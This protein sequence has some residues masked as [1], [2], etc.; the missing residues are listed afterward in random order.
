MLLF[1]H[2]FQREKNKKKKK[3]KIEGDFQ[4][5]P[6]AFADEFFYQMKPSHSINFADRLHQVVGHDPI[7]SC[8]ARN[9]GKKEKHENAT[10]DLP[11]NGLFGVLANQFL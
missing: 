7:H 8:Q 4:P 11:V 10:L 6:L 1:P 2:L 9:L 5:A 3:E